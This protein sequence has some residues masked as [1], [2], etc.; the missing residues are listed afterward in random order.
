MLPISLTAGH[1]K[2]WGTWGMTPVLTTS[3]IASGT[4]CPEAG[5]APLVR[6][7]AQNIYLAP[8]ALYAA[9]RWRIAFTAGSLSGINFKARSCSRIASCLRPIAQQAAAKES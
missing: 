3:R 1:K 4:I 2:S 5:E 8:T 7:P 9:S 6:S